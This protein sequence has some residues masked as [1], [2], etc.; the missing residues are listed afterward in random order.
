MEIAS[1]LLKKPFFKTQ[2]KFFEEI[3]EK[4]SSRDLRDEAGNNFA[5]L[6]ILNKRLD[7]LDRC[8]HLL[9]IKNKKG[10]TPRDLLKYIE[11]NPSSSD[12]SICV[13]KTKEESFDFFDRNK[14]QEFFK[15]NHLNN[16]KFTPEN[17]VWVIKKCEKKLSYEPIRKRNQWIDSLYGNA[18]L[19]SKGARTYI[20]WISPLIGYGLF[21]KEDIPQ[22]SFIGEYTGVVRKRDRQL[23][24]YN[25]YIF[26]YVVAGDE[27]S[28]VIDA[29]QE[30]NQTRFINHSDEP[31]LYS[32]WLISKGICHVILVSKSY[33]PKDT[34][35]TYDYGPTY[36]KKRTDP[37]EL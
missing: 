8:Q 22:Y 7:F 6:C 28:F 15:I 34:Q 31:N 21:A 3:F 4:Y 17:L 27:T 16:L 25:D 14:L 13:Y 2:K 35:L 18:F 36:W 26:G 11:N 1:A 20:K 10:L 32:T 12:V 33:I 5:H 23:D 29:Y 24:R 30:G 19:A 37:L 9:D